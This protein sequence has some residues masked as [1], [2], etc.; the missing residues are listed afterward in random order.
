[1]G[2]LLLKCPLCCSE[3]F[4]SREMLVHHLSKVWLNLRCPVCNDECSSISHML[5]HLNQSNCVPKPKKTEV[6]TSGPIVSAAIHNI[7]EGT[8]TLAHHNVTENQADQMLNQSQD[9][10]D[11]NRMYVELLNKQLTKPCLQ[12]QELKLVKEDGESRYVIV[13]QE[14]TM[15]NSGSTVFTKQNSDGTISLTT[16]KDMKLE[17]ADPDPLMPE[18]EP[19]ESQ[20]IYSCN[21]CGVS[22][23]SVIEHIQNYHND[24]EVVVEESL[25]SCQLPM[26]YEQMNGEDVTTG[27]LQQSR[28]VIT[29]TGDIVEAPVLLNATLDDSHLSMEPLTTDLLV[30]RKSKPPRPVAMVEKKMVQVDSV[31]TNLKQKEDI[32]K[33]PY[34]KVIVKEM[35][36]LEGGKKVKVYN[37]M[38]CN[39]YVTSL[40]EF[41][42]QPC[43]PQTDSTGPFKCDICSTIF[44]SNKSLKLHKRMHDPVKARPIELPVE[45]EGT[46]TSNNKYICSI[47]DK[48]IPIDYRAVHNNSHNTDNKYNC[49]ICNRKF[50]SSEYL[51]MHMSVHN[52]DKAPVNKQDKSLPYNCSY[53]TRQFAR[54][55]EKV[56]HERIHTGEKPHSCEICGKSFRVSYCLTL[57]MRTHTGARP[58]ACPHCNKRFKAHSVYNHHLLTHSEV[59]A[60]KCP[61]CPKAFKTSV[62]LAG[63]KNSHTKPFSC[64]HC[65]RPFA[66]LYAV[67]A[68]TETHA[69]QNNLKFACTLC[70]ASYARTFALKDHIKQVHNKELDAVN[71]TTVD[72]KEEGWILSEGDIQGM[73]GRQ[74]VDDMQVSLDKSVPNEINQLVINTNEAE[75]V[76]IYGSPK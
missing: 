6:V 75:S 22:F 53:C 76:M 5:D 38:T 74:D 65:N 34:H 73:D 46:E 58:Y 26:E 25:D 14:D 1:M 7:A 59:R 42:S 69:R 20:E 16:V 10:S 3:V 33:G 4:H 50:H 11:I 30:E 60:Y 31:V 15:L 43:K 48:L 12:T 36:M 68:H 40:D 28:R 66:S 32:K 67:R 61:Y 72:L 9:V 13:T 64:Q 52:L 70:G 39:I 54:P 49:D 37:C 27:E 71:K 8:P 44:P 41:K 57:H 45:S 24:Q 51:E 21:T 19:E 62:Q 63:H 18:N 29:D 56:K 35:Q 23:S 2:D 55:H 17:A 47:C